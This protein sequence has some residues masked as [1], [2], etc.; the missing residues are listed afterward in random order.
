MK[1][2]DIKLDPKAV[3]ELR[4]YSHELLIALDEAYELKLASHPPNDFVI[5]YS[6]NC[7]NL[8]KIKDYCAS[9]NATAKLLAAH[10]WTLENLN[11]VC[12]E[13]QADQKSNTKPE[14]AQAS[15]IPIEK[16]TAQ[17]KASGGKL[18]TTNEACEYL[19]I[20]YHVFKQLIETQKIE[21]I[22]PNKRIFFTQEHLDS[23]LK[24]KTEK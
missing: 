18:F 22:R 2:R 23:Y 6:V 4:K 20:S 5:R 19:G 9:I 17:E 11:Y 10:P 21:F 12:S 7:E 13:K 24:S 8:E 14:T 15:E 16:R 1:D 3:Q